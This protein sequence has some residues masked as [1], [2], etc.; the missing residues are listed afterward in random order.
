MVNSSL[1]G[2]TVQLKVSNFEVGK[3]YYEKLLGRTPDTMFLGN[4]EDPFGNRLG[5]YQDIS[6]NNVK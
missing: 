2:V 4:F 5:L 3:Q 6:I 1:S